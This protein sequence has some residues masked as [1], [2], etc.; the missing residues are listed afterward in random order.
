MKGQPRYVRIRSNN[1]F[2]IHA[3]TSPFYPLF[4]ALGINAH[5]HGAKVGDDVDGLR[6]DGYRSAE[7]DPRELSVYCRLVP[8]TVHGESWGRA[9]IATN[10]RFFHLVPANA[11]S[12]LRDMPTPEFFRP[13]RTALTTAGIDA[14][15]GEYDDFGVAA[16]ILANFC[17]KTASCR[18]NATSLDSLLLTPAEAMGNLQQL[19]AQL[20]RFENCSRAMCRKRFCPSV[21]NIP[22]VMRIIPCAGSARGCTIST[23]ATT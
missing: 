7:T 21:S 8:E 15:T 14:R 11:G 22:N 3:S 12:L 1:A 18:K 17:V 23:P 16:T 13:G 9:N 20:V 4:A 5:M 19:V 2:M 10:L 6:G